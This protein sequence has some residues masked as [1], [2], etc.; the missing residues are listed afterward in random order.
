M[1]QSDSGAASQIQSIKNRRRKQ[2]QQETME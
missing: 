2:K 1:A